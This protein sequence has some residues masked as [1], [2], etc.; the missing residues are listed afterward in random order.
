MQDPI[1]DVDFLDGSTRHP[2]IGKDMQNPEKELEDIDL[3]A[4][5]ML[6]ESQFIVFDFQLFQFQ[7]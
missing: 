2:E 4:E 3:S 7:E 6:K 1:G 5:Y